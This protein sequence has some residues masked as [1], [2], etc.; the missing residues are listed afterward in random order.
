MLALGQDHSAKADHPLAAHCVS[1]DRERLE[2]DLVFGDQ[3]IR[4]VDIALIDLG[5]GNEAIDV[6]RMAALDC[7]GVKFFILDLQVDALLDLVAAPLVFGLDR[8]AALFIDKLLTKAMACLLIDLPEGD[9]LAGGRCG[10]ER[11]RTRDEGK[12]EI[13]LPKWTRWGHGNS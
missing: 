10:V 3:V 2:G 1:D 5:F 12:L 7:D 9:A 4:A 11:Y 13:A 8:L 6:D